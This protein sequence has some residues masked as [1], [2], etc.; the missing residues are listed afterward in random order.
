[1]LSK[2]SFS[3]LT[4]FFYLV[5]CCILKKPYHNLQEV[6]S[7]ICILR[8]FCGG[9]PLL[10][11]AK[12]GRRHTKKNENKLWMK[13]GSVWIAWQLLLVW[14]P[15]LTRINGIPYISIV[16]KCFSL[17]LCLRRLFSQFSSR[18]FGIF[19]EVPYICRNYS[20]DIYFWQILAEL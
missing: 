5:Q 10:V 1:M 12:V 7:Y 17:F 16:H 19:L 20:H 8:Q 9:L 14:P 15:D 18:P 6:F 4:H 11:K 3:I 2:Y 13:I